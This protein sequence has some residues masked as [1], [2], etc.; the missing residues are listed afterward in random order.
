MQGRGPQL[1]KG[2][3]LSPSW[4][5]GPAL[6]FPVPEAQGTL[7]LTKVIKGLE[8]LPWKGRLRAG[9]VSLE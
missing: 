5:L 3:P 8:H 9:V 2:I 1:F 7:L 6:G 4:V